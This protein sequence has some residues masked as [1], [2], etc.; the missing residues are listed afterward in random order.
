MK[1]FSKEVFMNKEAI[2]AKAL[3][4]M[5][6]G[7]VALVGGG[8]AVGH[9]FGVSAGANRM[10]NEMASA[11]SEANAKENKAIADSF[12]AFNKKENV[13]LANKYLRRGVNIGYRMAS[14]KPV[15][16]MNKAA[17]DISE[18]AFHDELEKLGF[19]IGAFA[20]RA[21]SSLR[22][23]G[24][25][26]KGASGQLGKALATKGSMQQSYISNATSM[27]G[28]AIKGSPRAAAGLGGTVALG[29]AY[30]SGRATASPK[31]TIVDYRY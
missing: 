12:K 1:T 28:R 17:S 11:F 19:P 7:G 29:G 23:L 10:G 26:F 3:L 24:A 18:E 8:A 22:R 27:A 21:I 15:A 5:V 20:S 16:P 30:T 13:M 14:T 6:G 25:G 2:A 4:G 31:R 9:R